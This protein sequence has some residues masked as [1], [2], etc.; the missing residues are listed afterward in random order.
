LIETAVEE[1]ATPIFCRLAGGEE[2]ELPALRVLLLDFVAIMRC[3]EW[4]KV[5][6]IEKSLNSF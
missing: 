1:D 6:G 2:D 3:V 5:V 4:A